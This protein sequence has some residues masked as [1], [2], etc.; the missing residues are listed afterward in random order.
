MP[1]KDFDHYN[2]SLGYPELYYRIGDINK[3]RETAETLADIFQQKLKYYSTFNTQDIDLIIDNL[4][5]TLYMYQNL[6]QQIT[7]YDKDE[8]YGKKFLKII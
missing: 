8:D 5:T 1:I 6:V 7:R 2:F 3:A 4:E